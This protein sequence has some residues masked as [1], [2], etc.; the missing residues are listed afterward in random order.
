VHAVQTVDR[1]TDGELVAL[2]RRSLHAEPSR[3]VWPRTETL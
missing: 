3:M 2:A 1:I